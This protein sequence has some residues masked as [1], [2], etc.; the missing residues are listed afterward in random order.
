MVPRPHYYLGA[1]RLRYHG[2]RLAVALEAEACELVKDPGALHTADPRLV[3]E[4]QPLRGATHRFVSEIAL[5][6]ARVIHHAAATHAERDAV[7]LR[8]TSLHADGEP[9][10]VVNLPANAIE[11]AGYRQRNDPNAGLPGDGFAVILGTGHHGIDPV[12]ADPAGVATVSLV[13]GLPDPAALRA[14]G[15]AAAAGA[16]VRLL[17][18]VDRPHALA[19]LVPAA[20]ARNLA[21]TIH[22]AVT[23]VASTDEPSL[24]SK[25]PLR[26]ASGLS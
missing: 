19:F 13:T 24:R 2:G 18:N 22:S 9:S 20:E 4:A 7:A 25:P 12:G 11:L 14:A 1:G 5:A 8:F 10:T 26:K 3:P 23:L 17:R 21:R 16:G 6:G 15:R